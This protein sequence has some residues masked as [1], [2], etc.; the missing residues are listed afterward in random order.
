MVVRGVDP[1]DVFTLRGDAQGH[2]A[3]AAAARA[4]LLHTAFGGSARLG[5][6]VHACSRLQQLHR[7]AS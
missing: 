5:G 4:S 6:A 7:L 2:A 3:A 1:D